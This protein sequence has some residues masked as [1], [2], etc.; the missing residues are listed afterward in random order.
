MHS[1][2]GEKF[3]AIANYP[4]LGYQVD[5]I[6]PNNKLILGTSF[7]AA[8]SD[9]EQYFDFSEVACG[10]SIEHNYNSQTREV[11]GKVNVN[12]DD[13]PDLGN[14]S[15]MLVVIQD[16][17]L[18]KQYDY[19][20]STGFGIPYVEPSIGYLDTFYHNHVV[21]DG[22]IN[23][24]D[25]LWG[26]TFASNP[27]NGQSFSVSFN[28]NLPEKYEFCGPGTITIPSKYDPEKVIDEQITLVAYVSR[29]NSEVVN[30]AKSHL[31]DD[32]TPISKNEA[33]SNF[34]SETINI[35]N[36]IIFV[37]SKNMKNKSLEI[38]NIHGKKI[39]T[40]KGKRQINLNNLNLSKGQYFIRLN[41]SDEDNTLVRCWVNR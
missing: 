37:N 14:Y 38:F 22:I 32:S 39:A 7:D 16:S 15:L 11:T 31:I 9:V 23:G 35:K 20:M 19:G 5:R 2:F 29:N 6:C 26:E 34:R 25:S 17:I 8:L 10:V 27:S 28:Y 18:Y 33:T 30:S 3:G 40:V 12:F 41:Y 24:N 13:T 21:R 1:Y 4:N 36:G